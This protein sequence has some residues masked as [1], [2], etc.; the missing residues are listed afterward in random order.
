MNPVRDA[1]GRRLPRNNRS[2][3]Y[4]D[5]NAASPDSV[6]T[7]AEDCLLAPPPNTL[8]R[9]EIFMTTSAV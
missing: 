9:Q 1:I 7:T 3:A 4:F 8:T 5:G 2:P 6:L